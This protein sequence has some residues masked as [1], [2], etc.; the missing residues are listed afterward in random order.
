MSLPNKPGQAD[1]LVQY[2]LGVLPPE[3]TERLDEASIV[4]D[5][6]AAR[7]RRVE[8]DLVDSYVR[9]QLSGDT[10][11]QFESHYLSSRHRRERV[12]F[13][14]KFLRAVDKVDKETSPVVAEAA[15][16]TRASKV[17][18]TLA[19]AATLSLIAGGASLLQTVRLGRGLREAQSD[20]VAVDQRARDLE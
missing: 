3:E 20:R 14:R 4:D 11:A 15:P 8:D 2:L 10:L 18:A 9:G 7:L 19:V 12:E 17:V 6:I 16:K 13:A 5:D 1:E